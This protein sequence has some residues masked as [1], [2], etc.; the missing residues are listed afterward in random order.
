MP[1]IPRAL[2][3]ALTLAAAG[4]A[5]ANEPTSDELRARAKDIRGAAEQDFKVTTYHCY[6]RFLVN[7]C[8]DDAKLARLEQ[9][10]EARVLEAK[11]NKMDRS[12]RVKAMEAR[13]RKIESAP[14]TPATPA[15]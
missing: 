11:A 1:L 12:K 15:Q 5:L 7:A 14:G 2:C 9:V 13:L 10:K 4:P 6:D 3:L 8:L